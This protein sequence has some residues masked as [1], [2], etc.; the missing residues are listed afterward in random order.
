MRLRGVAALSLALSL[1]LLV[2]LSAS[3]R[4]YV[5]ISGG[6]AL[7][8]DSDFTVDGGGSGEFTFDPGL[9]FLAEV[10]YEVQAS[11]SRIGLEFG[12]RTNDI[13]EF[14]VD[15]VGSTSAIDGDAETV[16][17]MAN[18]YYDFSAGQVS[19]FLMAG[20]GLANVEGK[21]DGLAGD[22]S[23]DDTVFAYQ[24]G[25]GISVPLSPTVNL[26]GSYRYFGTEDP[27]LDGVE[28]EYGSHNLLATLRFR[29]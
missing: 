23:A 2:P 29:F 9:L 8:T 16:S 7:L 4:S 25:G 13:D 12:Y 28:L 5:S 22:D 14:S 17:F 19:P 15:G 18:G 3:A 10:G 20:A 11:G 21:I 27:D 24:F 26:D 6:M 1:T